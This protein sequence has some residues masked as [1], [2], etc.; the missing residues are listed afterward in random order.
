MPS[1]SGEPIGRLRYAA[2]SLSVSSSAIEEWAITR[3]RVVQRCPA[4]PAAAK[5]MPRTV[6]SR[7]ALGATIAAL[8]PPSSSS[9]RPKRPATTGATARPIRVEPVADTSATRGSATRASPTSGPPSTT[10]LT[11]SGAPARRAASA[12]SAWQASA[13]RMVFSDGFHTTVSPQTSASAVFHDHT[14]T[15][16]LK[17]LMTPTTPSGCHCS[18]MR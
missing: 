16:K 18:I 1:A 8:L 14:A 7:S 11:A 9:R 5:T 13:V 12:S 10:A 3:R 17:A 2:A 15:G 4:V 6:R